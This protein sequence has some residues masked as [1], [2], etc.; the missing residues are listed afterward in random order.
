MTIPTR[1]RSLVYHAELPVRDEPHYVDGYTCD[2]CKREFLDGPM[3]HCSST[4][5]DRC[6]YCSVAT[7]IHPLPAVVAELYTP[8]TVTPQQPQ[9][10]ATS[11]ERSSTPLAPLIAY[12]VHHRMVGIVLTRNHVMIVEVSDVSVVR[13]RVTDVT[14][15]HSTMYEGADLV[16]E[17]PFVERWGDPQHLEDERYFTTLRYGALRPSPPSSAHLRGEESFQWMSACL[18]V[19]AACSAGLQV[20]VF[21]DGTCQILN[22]CSGVGTVWGNCFGSS[23]NPTLLVHF[24]AARPGV[25]P[26]VAE[27][28][29]MRQT[30]LRRSL[31][32]VRSEGEHLTGVLLRMPARVEKPT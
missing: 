28:E 30:D 9:S 13:G 11:A 21:E 29:R 22:A 8:T 4:G 24:S 17:F 6:C 14:S 1:K 3:Y 20:F 15:S 19:A 31:S 25:C 23:K 7:G 2:T 32:L 10:A 5:E 26:S 16:T 18:L 27:E 12:R